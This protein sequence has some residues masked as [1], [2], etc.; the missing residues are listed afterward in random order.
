MLQQV[1]SE[2]LLLKEETTSINKNIAELIALNKSMQSMQARE[3][4]EQRI[5]NASLP[6]NVSWSAWTWNYTH[7][8]ARKTGVN[9]VYRYFVPKQAES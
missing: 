5:S 3:K 4:L 7:W 1:Q 6:A 2:F 8:V 9:A